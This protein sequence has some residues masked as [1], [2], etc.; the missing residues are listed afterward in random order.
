MQIKLMS[1]CAISK[2]NIKFIFSH[3]T[4]YIQS[5][6][7]Q[8]KL[9]TKIEALNTILKTKSKDFIVVIQIKNNLPLKKKV[10]EN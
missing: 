8:I 2:K 6:S 3:P 10:N 7:H 9:F 4:I 1:I 5:S